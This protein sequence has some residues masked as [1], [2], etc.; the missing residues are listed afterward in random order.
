MLS[1]AARTNDRSQR[2]RDASLLADHLAEIVLCDMQSKH[3]GVGL[4][5]SLDA[6]SVGIVDQLLRQVLEKLLH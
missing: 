4:V 6:H 3:D 5:D 2:T 1:H